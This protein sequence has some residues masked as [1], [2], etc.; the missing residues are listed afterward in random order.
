MGSVKRVYLIGVRYLFPHKAIPIHT[1]PTSL[2]AAYADTTLGAHLV[3]TV[4]WQAK[5]SGE[6]MKTDVSN[7]VTVAAADRVMPDCRPSFPAIIPPE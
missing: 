1:P 2:Q 3:A 7:P 6:P 4:S 5:R